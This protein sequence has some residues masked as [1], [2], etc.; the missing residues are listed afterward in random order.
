MFM[1]V[2]CIVILLKNLGFDC[3]YYNYCESWVKGTDYFNCK[4]LQHTYA[5]VISTHVISL[6]IT[7]G[8]LLDEFSIFVSFLLSDCMFTS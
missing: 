3:H 6:A 1:Y 4:S 5:Q 8:G 2:I 7:S